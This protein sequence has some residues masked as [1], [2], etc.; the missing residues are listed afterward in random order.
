M[1]NKL[2][3]MFI[4]IGLTSVSIAAQGIGDRNRA[5]EGGGYTI[6]GRVYLPD[7]KPAS[8][9]KVLVESVDTGNR[10]YYTDMDGVFQTGGIQAGNYAIIAAVPGLPVEREFITIGREEPLRT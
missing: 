7:G 2:L 4:L 1:K 5:A 6:Q 10:S 9:L 3:L 8:N